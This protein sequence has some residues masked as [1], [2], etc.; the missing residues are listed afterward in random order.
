MRPGDP[1]AIEK[2]FNDVAP[3]YDHLNDLL[4][5]GLHRVWKKRLLFLLSP[6]PGEHWLDLCCGTGDLTLALARKVCPKGTVMGV[7]SAIEPLL[8]AT[9]RSSK[10][11]F[12]NLSWRK[13][14]AL[15][16][17]LPSNYFD[18]VV[19]AYGL[20]NLADPQ[21]GLKEVHRVLKPGGRAG[22]LDFNQIA[23][24][25][26]RSKFQKFY[27]RR[28]VVPIADKAGLREHYLYLEKS[29][30]KFPQGHIQEKLALEIGFKQANHLLLAFSQMG[31]LLLK[32]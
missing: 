30:Q 27:L 31:I 26:I 14:D 19:M 12:R 22:I 10:E 4:S 23:S 13:G 2:L 16:T 28:V 32:S 25:S 9:K 17:G 3:I 6:M 5:L 7:D 29:L 8:I 24:N 1:L 11:S 20:R 15:D 21:A 18:G